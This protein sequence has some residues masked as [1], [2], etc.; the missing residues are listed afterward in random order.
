MSEYSE[1][2][3]LR[4]YNAASGED[5]AKIFEELGAYPSEVTNPGDKERAV[6]NDRKLAEAAI[7]HEQLAAYWEEQNNIHGKLAP[8]MDGRPDKINTEEAIEHHQ[9]MAKGLKTGD[10][11]TSSDE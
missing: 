8:D 2:E 6:E 4:E 11:S 3:K 10:W 5:R 7:N 1:S 9:Q